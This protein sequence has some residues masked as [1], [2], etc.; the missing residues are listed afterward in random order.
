[1]SNPIES[2]FFYG[3]DGDI[4]SFFRVPKRLVRNAR[5]KALS[6]NAKLLYGLF[7]DRMDLSSR[8][9]WRDEYNRVYI[10]YPVKEIQEE[11]HCGKNTPS[12][13]INE[14]LDIGLIE[15]RHPGLG[16]P[17]VIY[18]KTIISDSQPDKSESIQEH[19]CVVGNPASRK[20]GSQ[21][22]EIRDAGI[23]K[24]GKPVSRNSGGLIRKN[25]T[26][27]NQ[28]E[29]I[30]PSI[31]PTQV[32]ETREHGNDGMDGLTRD[33]VRRMVEGNISGDILRDRYDPTQV[34]EIAALILPLQKPIGCE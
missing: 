4:Q 18:V 31:Q 16:R 27:M 24:N 26:D 19:D 22:P 21:S 17:D 10:Y 9:G 33:D 8:N 20:T 11:L 13:L 12:I 3:N 25:K 5:Y 30:N 32:M 28:T 15:K 1:M 29:Y 7:L 2:D 14:L 23:P 34:D 6:G